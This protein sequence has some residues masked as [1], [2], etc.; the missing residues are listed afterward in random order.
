MKYLIIIVLVYGLWGGST[1]LASRPEFA[2]PRSVLD[3]LTITDPTV[4]QTWYG[5]LEGWPHTYTFTLTT[6]TDLAFSVLVPVTA[7]TVRASLNAILITETGQQGAVSEVARI[8]GV[9]GAGEIITH[10]WGREGYA[11]VG[12]YAATLPPG[13]YRLEVSTPINEGIYALAF[14]GSD[15]SLPF[16]ETVARLIAVR[17]FI[18]MTP[19]TLVFVPTLAYPIGAILIL[20]CLAW[21]VRRWWH[22]RHD[23]ITP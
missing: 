1:A 6:D 23:T 5:R 22:T 11:V 10:G 14:Y 17:Q 20:A 7:T 2:E 21:F 15:A 13:T 19:L 3:T 18:G 8:L 4:A 9:S 12:S 16:F